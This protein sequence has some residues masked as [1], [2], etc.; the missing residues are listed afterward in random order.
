MADIVVRR[1]HRYQRLGIGN[2]A[3]LEQ[4]NREYPSGDVM[5]GGLL[6]IG[7][8]LLSRSM[9]YR[10]VEYLYDKLEDG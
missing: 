9:M 1:V 4:S 6:S 7:M 10:N 3:G 2:S 5:A 8:R